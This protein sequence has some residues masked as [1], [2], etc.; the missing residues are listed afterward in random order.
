MIPADTNSHD[1]APGDWLPP[2]ASAEAIDISTGVLDR[3]TFLK[4]SLTATGG[5]CLMSLTGCSRTRGAAGAADAPPPP[6][7]D[8]AAFVRIEPD[9]TVVIGARCPEIGQGVKTALPMIIAEELDAEWSRVRVEQLPLGLR[10]VP[11]PPGVTWRYGPQGAG[12]STSIPNAWA[13]HRQIG[14]RARHLL[15]RAAAARWQADPA[16]LTTRDG[17][18]RHPDGRTLGY[19]EL[20]AAAATLPLPEGDVPL[21]DPADYRIVGTPRRVADARDIVTG[22]A[23]YGIDATLPGALVAVIARCPYFQGEL[24]SFDATAAK[25]VPGVRDVVPLPGPAAGEPIT[26][27]L[28][29]GVAV[30]AEDTWSALK[31]REALTVEWRRGPHAEE[32]SRALDEQC[33]RLLR[34]NGARVR[35]DGDFDAA[36]TKAARVVEA[37]YRVPFVAHCPLEPQNACAHVEADRVTIVAPMQQPS[38]ASRVAHALTGIDRTRIDVR[39]TRVGGGFGRRLANDFVA[40]AVL[41][42]K[43]TGWPIKVVWTREDD[44]AHDWFRP[45]GHHHMIAALD[46]GGRVTGWAHRLASASKYYRRPDVKPEDYWTAELYTDDF[47][48][49]LVPN[50]RLEWFG[51][52][53]GMTRGSWRAPAHTANAF[54]VQ[55]FLDEIA[56]AAGRDPLELRLELLGPSRELPYEQHGGP[57]FDTGRLAHVLRRAAERIGW[58]RPATPGRGAG[59]AAHFTFGGYTGHAM[60]VSVGDGGLR[61]ERCVCVVDVGRPINPLGIEAQMM[62]GTIDGISTA[63][64]LE[65]TIEG[66]R[67]VERNFDDYP[68][69]GMAQAPDVEVEI[70]RSEA[71]PV[72]A[73]E[74]GIPTAAP[75]LVNAIFAATGRRIRALPVRDAFRA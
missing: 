12:G 25:Q 13:D 16:R 73:G 45:F 14:A 46:D 4:L 49:R 48:A 24:A 64:G 33:A 36:R 72:G 42:S 68:L 31:G 70:V 43:A 56:H 29:A 15:V 53:S 8:V 35:E 40:E 3:R 58:P 7:P 66:G 5:L 19:G 9:G 61:I 32:S 10:P 47:P 65:I 6:P 69:L 62:G 59:L 75:A 74:M 71:D 23:G 20:A 34:G 22:R 28:A 37:T 55:S 67:V 1:P 21:K 2:R 50:L 27:N 51:V 30:I 41:L 63:L 52:E 57:V 60:E 17:V 18:V 11:E 54:V 38:G 26:A 39:M 44:L